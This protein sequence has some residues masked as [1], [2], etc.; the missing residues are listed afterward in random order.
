MM[1]KIFN[2]FILLMII[3][4]FVSGIALAKIDYKG[5][6]TKLEI[7]TDSAGMTIAQKNGQTISFY[8]VVSTD[9]LSSEEMR[10]MDTMSWFPSIVDYGSDVLV[11]SNKD[12]VLLGYKVLKRPPHLWIVI[13]KSQKASINSGKPYELTLLKYKIYEMGYTSDILHSDKFD[14]LR[15]GYYIVAAGGFTKH[16]DAVKCKDKLVSKGIP[17]AYIKKLW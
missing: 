7:G 10:I 9:G 6:V 13:A 3:N 12:K 5:V 11:V 1:K 15:N 16:A 17:D 8:S 14:A 2:I 4:S